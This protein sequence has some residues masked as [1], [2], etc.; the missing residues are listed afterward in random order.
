[1][2]R[3]VTL[4]IPFVFFSSISFGISI[5]L[6]KTVGRVMPVVFCGSGLIL[7]FS[8]LFLNT[9]SV[10]YY[11]LIGVAVLSLVYTITYLI[12]DRSL[13]RY[14]FTGGF[15]AFAVVYFV[16]CYI[17]VGKTLVDW[18]E[19]THWG[20]MVKESLRIDRFYFVPDSFLMWHR[21]YPPFTC[22]LETLWCKLYGYSDAHVTIAMQVFTLSFI[23]PWAVEVL[24]NNKSIKKKNIGKLFLLSFAIEFIVMMLC[25]SLDLWNQKIL[26]SILPDVL[27]SFMM[28]YLC[29]LV[30]EWDENNK[31]Q[32]GAFTIVSASL[33][34]VKQVGIAFY[35]VAVFMLVAKQIAFRKEEYVKWSKSIAT[36]LFVMVI[37]LLTMVTW[38]IAKGK[39][40]GADDFSRENGQFNLRQ[41]KFKYYFDSV[42]GKEKGLGNET[43]RNYYKA[44]FTRDLSSISGIYITYFS[45]FLIVLLIFGLLFFLYK[46]R[47]GK[48]NAIILCLTVI[49]STVGYAFA[50]SVLYVNCFTDNEKKDLAGY[51]RYMGSMVVALMLLIFVVVVKLLSQDKDKHKNVLRTGFVTIGIMVI[52]SSVNLYHMTNRK[53][54][55]VG[56]LEYKEYA[57]DITQK[58]E[59]G[60]T[61]FIIYDKEHTYNTN[62]YV[63]QY[64]A[65]YWLDGIRIY[66]GLLGAYSYDLSKENNKS[67]LVN[68]LRECDYLY[69]VDVSESF[70]QNMAEYNSE[71]EYT[72]GK[73]YKIEQSGDSISLI[74]Q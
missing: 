71:M 26:N 49:I 13:I 17:L 57:D 73:Y 27:M 45:A 12:R 37:P 63:L 31:F 6:K 14:P 60:S 55:T 47:L 8:Q 25:F 2:L 20:M 33:L 62:W 1:M 22:M 54:E 56:Y 43:F 34:L 40:I 15:I 66:N 9:F 38:S 51:T 48:K 39:Y 68:A 65:Q 7:Y 21:D 29:L 42:T 36:N 44:L 50:M 28:A 19:Y 61:V 5:L 18:D 23:V 69:L 46:E 10:A 52:F 59:K 41:I 35:M 58:I 32:V 67:K 74:A 70:N 72:S 30:F 64:F 3:L 53:N 16:A 4:L 24:S 11:F